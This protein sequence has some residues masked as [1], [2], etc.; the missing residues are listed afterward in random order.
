VTA[1]LSA[2][3]PRVVGISVATI[4]GSGIGLAIAPD[5][6]ARL[7]DGRVGS[8]VLHRR[9]V[10]ADSAG[11]DVEM[12]LIDPMNRIRSVALLYA[13]RS[14]SE[15]QLQH[16]PDGSFDPFPGAQRLDLRIDGQK[17]TGRLTL[18]LGGSGPRFLAHQPVYVNGEGKTFYQ[19]VK[20]VE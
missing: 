18:A 3:A 15:P 12:H 5:E 16:K 1:R 20:T 17:A 7:F 6:L 11:Y 19:V 9:K 13:V 4:R 2:S 14:A 8:L 10:E